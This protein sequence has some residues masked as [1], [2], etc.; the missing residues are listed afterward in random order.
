MNKNSL[1]ESNLNK[2]QIEKLTVKITDVDKL[3]ESSMTQSLNK[4]NE[5]K[6]NNSIEFKNNEQYKTPNLNSPPRKSDKIELTSDKKYSP[7]SLSTIIGENLLALSTLTSEDNVEISD[8]CKTNIPINPSTRYLPVTINYKSRCKLMPIDEDKETNSKS[9]PSSIGSSNAFMESTKKSTALEQ[10]V[11]RKMVGGNGLIQE[12]IQ[13]FQKKCVKNDNSTYTKGSKKFVKKLV[14]SLEKSIHEDEN[15]TEDLIENNKFI[16]KSDDISQ[17]N[18]INNVNYSDRYSG[19]SS[20]T[21]SL[22]SSD[23]DS[24]GSEPS[25]PTLSTSPDYNWSTKV[26]ADIENNLNKSSSTKHKNIQ[27]IP[28]PDDTNLPRTSSALSMKSR[29]SSRSSSNKSPCI[30]PITEDNSQQRFFNNKKPYWSWSYGINNSTGRRGSTG[31]RYPV[32]D[33]GYAEQS[34]EHSL[35]IQSFLAEYEASHSFIQDIDTSSDRRSSFGRASSI[36]SRS[37][38]V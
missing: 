30:S 6:T 37:I 14:K 21:I 3:L 5:F 28:L 9:R 36:L 16:E 35:M 33:S 11:K 20:V 10:I 12:I 8:D 19:T 26:R 38:R 2:S 22:K 23:I 15:E 31:E 32:C 29:S 27:W 25:S 13:E 4:T 17:L 1:N 7:V 18:Q 34:S 24:G